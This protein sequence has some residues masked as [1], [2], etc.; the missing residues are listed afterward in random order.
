MSAS[1][2]KLHGK[3]DQ[4]SRTKAYLEFKK[5]S[6]SILICTDVASRGL[7]FEDVRLII[8]FDAP[9]SMTDYVNRMGRTARIGNYGMSLLFLTNSETDY[10]QM[11]GEK[12]INV[13]RYEQEE[14]NDFIEDKIRKDLNEEMSAHTFLIS[15]IREFMRNDIRHKIKGR[16]AYISYVRAYA[17]MKEKEIFHPKKLNLQLLVLL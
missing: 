1:I 17:K 10:I 13:E 15:R 11:L 3:I 2:F 16:K 6:N 7:D 9:S 14:Y 4:K 12:G 8:Q 5:S